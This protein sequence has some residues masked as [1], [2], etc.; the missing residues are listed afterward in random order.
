[1]R[2]ISVDVV[3]R[4]VEALK[5]VLG[6][7]RSLFS[8]QGE[9]G[10]VQITRSHREE[11]SAPDRPFK[12]RDPDEVPS[13]MRAFE[14]QERSCFVLEPRERC[15]AQEHQLVIEVI[16]APSLRTGTRRTLLGADRGP[17]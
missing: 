10:S 13:D 16:T 11:D 12:S 9:R 7:F 5:E 14:P 6:E 4:F 2:P 1:V 3:C 8:R 17:S 15:E